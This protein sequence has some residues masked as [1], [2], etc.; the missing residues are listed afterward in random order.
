MI[1]VSQ[2]T[3]QYG[4]KILY[5]NGSFQINPGEKIGLVGPNGAGKTTIFR[6]LTREENV[7]AGT[8]TIPEKLVVGYFSQNIEDLKGRSAIEEVKAGAGR[9]SIVGRELLEIEQ[10]LQ[11]PM[12]EDEMMRVLDVYGRLQG[13]FEQLGGYDLDAR[14]AEILTGL[15]I[16]P[17]DY[18]RPVESFS[19]G[20]KMR[21][22]LA[23][24]LAQKP[25]VLLMDEPTN[26]LD[27]ESIMWLEQW[28]QQYPGALLMMKP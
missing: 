28:L 15:G 18:H 2:V 3:K 11:Q 26:H 13:E 23:K 14:A 25:D 24:I 1:A 27:L 20:W 4:S 8:V 22:E 16:G 21:I 7:D 9:V 6:I 10:K 19:G 5:K 17:E 12:E